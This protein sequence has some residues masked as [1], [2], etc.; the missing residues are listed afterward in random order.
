MLNNQQKLKLSSMLILLL[1]CYGLI[2]IK[3]YFI[4]IQ[5]KGFFKDRAHRQYHVRIT[6]APERGMDFMI[7]PELRRLPSIKIALSAFI[8]FLI[9]YKDSQAVHNFLQKNFT[10]AHN[11]LKQHKQQQ[12][13]YIQR[14]LTPQEIAIIH[15]ANFPDPIF[16]RT[17]S[18]LSS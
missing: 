12:F 15:Q 3:L 4:Q 7:T 2:I 8:L 1:F 11:R 6:A 18:I 5:Q 13:M 17:K 14:H 10:Q 9:I 16:N